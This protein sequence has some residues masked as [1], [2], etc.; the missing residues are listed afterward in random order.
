[1]KFL[2]LST[3][4]API[5]CNTII[6]KSNKDLV[7]WNKPLIDWLNCNP[8]KQTKVIFLLKS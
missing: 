7:N 2:K 8:K 6:E 1:M 3:Y 4:Q 5:A